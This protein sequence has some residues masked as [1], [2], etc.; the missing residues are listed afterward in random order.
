MWWLRV[1]SRKMK[2]NLVIGPDS[3]LAEERDLQTFR[4]VLGNNQYLKFSL[5]EIACCHCDYLFIFAP[6]NNCIQEIKR[7]NSMQVCREDCVETVQ[8]SKRNS[9]HLSTALLHFPWIFSHLREPG[10]VC[11]VLQGPVSAFFQV[12]IQTSAVWG[13]SGKPPETS[14]LLWSSE[15]LGFFYSVFISPIVSLWARGIRVVP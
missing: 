9:V 2:G 15:N 1:K 12:P 6:V 3:R 13:G 7:K 10:F 14:L 11:C 5:Q 4:L 8:R